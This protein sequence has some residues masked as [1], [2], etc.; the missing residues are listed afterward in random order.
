MD[1]ILS[2]RVD[3]SVVRRL[4]LLAQKLKTTKKSIIEEAILAF[5]EKAGDKGGIDVF[6]QTLG[7]W[8]R[9]ELPEVTVKKA[10]GL[11]QRSMER[12]HR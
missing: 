2:A 11:F 10:R 9:D 6:Q 4:N 1:R 7:S 12:H 3:E 5:E 8:K